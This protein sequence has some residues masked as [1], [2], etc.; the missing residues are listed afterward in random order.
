MRE[1][2]LDIGCRKHKTK[3]AIG[4]DFVK[5]PG[6]DKVHDLNKIPYPFD[7]NTFDTI[8]SNHV[9]EHLD[10][11]LDKIL[12]ELCRICKPT[13]SLEITVPHA[14]SV[15]AFADSTHKKF[16]TYFTFD[17]FG[18]NEQSYYSK[19][20]IEIIKKRFFYSSGKLSS[21]LLKPMEYL[22]NLTPN[23]YSHFF[24]FI[25]P[26]SSIYFKLKPVK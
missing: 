8:Y 7:D 23:I 2:T 17:Y 4:L 15:G 22:I 11:D 1:K 18:S 21:K 20:R 5:M 3:G 19:S 16:F 13:G 24:A 6:V 9:L 10:A 25:F 12:S 14:M 26:I